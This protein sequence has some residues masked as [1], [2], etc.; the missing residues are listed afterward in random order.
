M[1]VEPAAG[2][3]GILVEAL[4]RRRIAP[5]E[6]QS[7]IAEDA[8]R[9]ADVSHDF[10]DA[11]FPGCV[12]REGLRLR[13]AAQQRGGLAAVAHQRLQEIAVGDLADVGAVIGIVLGGRGTWDR[14]GRHQ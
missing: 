4:D 10:F 1:G 5:S 7:A 14:G 11:P 13:N 8:L 2:D 9:I 12:A 6:P 3:V